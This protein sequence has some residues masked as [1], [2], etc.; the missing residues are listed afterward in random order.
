MLKLHL[1]H[2]HHFP[3]T[4][5]RCHGDVADDSAAAAVEAL[6]LRRRRLKEAR[7]NG[8]ATPLLRAKAVYLGSDPARF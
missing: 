1:D 4:V 7:K 5:S 6:M 8:A 3:R 2:P